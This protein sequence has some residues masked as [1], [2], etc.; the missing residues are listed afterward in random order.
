MFRTSAASGTR[1]DDAHL[2]LGRYTARAAMCE[3]EKLQLPVGPVQA[4]N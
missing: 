2:S 1:S 4:A 3:T